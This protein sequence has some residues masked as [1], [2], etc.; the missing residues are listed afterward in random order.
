M[1]IDDVGTYIRFGTTS[2][3]S[4]SSFYTLVSDVHAGVHDESLYNII[5]VQL[6]I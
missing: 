3:S 1:Y 6:Y 4:S 2:G 5:V